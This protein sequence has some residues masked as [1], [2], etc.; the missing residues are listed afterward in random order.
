MKFSLLFLLPLALSVSAGVVVRDGEWGYQTCP[1][2][3]KTST[4]TSTVTKTDTVTDTKT[5]TA[6][7]TTCEK[8]YGYP[9]ATYYAS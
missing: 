9:E 4:T 2:V 3:T 6:T 7:V 5:V 8:K 1:T